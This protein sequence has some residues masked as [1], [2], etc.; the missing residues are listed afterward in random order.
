[1]L[2]NFLAHALSY[3]CKNYNR[4]FNSE[5]ALHQHLHDSPAHTISYDCEE[6]L[7]MSRDCA[8]R[9]VVMS[10]VCDMLQ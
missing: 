4:S 5:G 3:N 6:R 9:A 10:W 1:H 8:C 2:R 7:C